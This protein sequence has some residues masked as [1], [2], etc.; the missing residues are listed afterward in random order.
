MG[1][2]AVVGDVLY[3]YRWSRPYFGGARKGQSCRVLWR[4]ARNSALVRWED[5]SRDVV[6]RNALRRVEPGPAPA[7]GSPRDAPL[8]RGARRTP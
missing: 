1:Y 7:V 6:S 8:P 5:G 4:G 3:S 2:K